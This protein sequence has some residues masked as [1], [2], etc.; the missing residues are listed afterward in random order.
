MRQIAV[1]GCGQ[2]GSSVALT[3]TD[4]GHEVLAIDRSEEVIDNLKDKVAHAVVC[5]VT[6][7]GSLKELGISNFDVVVIGMA[8]DFEASVM[9]TVTAKDLGVKR[10]IAKVQE[11]LHGRVL[12]RVGADKVVI[13]EKEI[14]IRLA[15]NLNNRS[16]LEFIELSKEYSIMEIEVPTSWYNMS[17]EDLRIREKTGVNVV[18]IKTGDNVDVSPGPK[19]KFREKQ[20]VL[21]IG[22]EKDIKKIENDNM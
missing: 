20:S 9:A 4:L 21:L 5:D 1:I 13:P 11:Q 7:E 8:T 19:A 10:V 18:A 16:T 22:K 3:L 6:I 14:G 17:I 2:F 12:T 15:H